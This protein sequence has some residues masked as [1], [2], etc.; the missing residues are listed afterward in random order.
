MASNEEEWFGL[1]T[2]CSGGFF[3]FRRY[4]VFRW[5]GDVGAARLP[6]FVDFQRA[7]GFYFV[8]NDCIKY[9]DGF[10]AGAGGSLGEEK[11][12]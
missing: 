9:V 1:P 10:C 6:G 3:V 7:R 12:G 4:Q 11:I 8:E 5:L 2:G